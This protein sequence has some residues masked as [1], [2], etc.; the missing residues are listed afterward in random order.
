MV[1]P[2]RPVSRRSKRSTVTL[3]SNRLKK[4][5]L[6]ASKFGNSRIRDRR[7]L[8]WFSRAMHREVEQAS[9]TFALRDSSE[10]YGREFAPENEVLTLKN[11][12]PWQKFAETTET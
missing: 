11:T 4:Q 10:A 12:I 3:S 7:H 1:P 2:L 6:R 8:L 9:E 5:K